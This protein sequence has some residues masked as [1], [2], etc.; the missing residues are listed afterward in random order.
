VQERYERL[1]ELQEQISAEEN[2]ALIGSELEVL[3]ATN[4]G[5]RDAETRRMSGRAEDNRLVHFDVPDGSELP[6]PGDVV[7]VQVTRSA[8][9][10]LIAAP[11]GDTLPVR[12]TRAGDAWDRATSLVVEHDHTHDAPVLPG[13]VISGERSVGL[14]IPSLRADLLM[15]PRPQDV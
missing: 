1:I 14:G 12:R 5:K 6:R 15:A 2:A 11:S 9:H 10:F 8:P 4:E 13:A 3:V 7:T